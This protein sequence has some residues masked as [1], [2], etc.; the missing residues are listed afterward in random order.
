M[1]RGQALQDQF[2]MTVLKQKRDG[3]FLEIGSNHPIN[4]NNSYVLENDYGWKGIMVE[5]DP[6]FLP[7]YQTHRPNSI[8]VINDATKVDY[9]NI[10]DNNNFPNHMDYL[11]IDL[12][13]NNGST[14]NT[15]QLLDQ[16][17]FD[18]YTFATVTFE[19]DIYHTNFDNT[20]MKSRYIFQKR[21]YVRVFSDV[22][23]QGNPFEDWYVHPL[24]V[25]MN[26]VNS[27]IER[28]AEKYVPHTITGTTID[29][30]N[31]EFS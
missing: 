29:W 7:A 16:Q 17:V 3:Y 20:R 8:H 9:K 26:L 21:G 15:L 19:H 5:Y 28:N 30:K 6:A 18:T 14:I 27:L 13:A 11:Q 24:L 2:I 23:N 12:E 25:D 22:S 1:F 31:I 10:M 4:I